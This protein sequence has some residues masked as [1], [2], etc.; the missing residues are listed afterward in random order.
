MNGKTRKPAGH[1][2]CAL[3]IISLLFQWGCA[4]PGA[5]RDEKSMETPVLET[6]ALTSEANRS[7]ITITS[8]TE[9]I[10]SPSFTLPSPPRICLDIKG[11]PS[12]TFSHALKAESGPVREV[13][14]Q[15]RGSEY[16]GIVIYLRE[17]GKECTI[18]TEGPVTRIVIGPGDAAKQAA[19]GE[20]APITVTP[21]L[22]RILNVQVSKPKKNT[23]RLTI[24]CEREL[25][26]Q[27]KPNGRNLALDLKD[28]TISP[29]LIKKLNTQSFEG[30]LESIKVVHP[31]GARDVFLNLT[32]RELSPYYINWEGSALHLDFSAFPKSA[33]GSSA[34]SLHKTSDSSSKKPSK[35]S[36][37]SSGKKDAGKKR[38]DAKA[39]MY[40][41][42]SQQYA[43]QRMSFDFVDTDIRNILRLISEVA[44][45]NIVWGTDVAGKI[46]MTMN[47]VPWDQAIEMILRPNGLTYQ[48]END[49]LWVVPK[50]KLV[51]MEIADK[52]RK[53]ALMAAKRLQGIFEAKIIEFIV[54]RNRKAADIY[55]ML[56]GDRTAKPPVMGILDIEGGESE[57]KEKG[58]EEQ[59]KST[60]IKAL[61]LYL[62]Y[63]AGTNMIVANG[64][65]AKIEKVKEFI[66]KLDVAERQVMIE[67]RVVEARTTFSRDLGIRWS[68]LDQSNPGFQADWL[69]TGSNSTGSTQ[70]S[71]NSP[72]TWSPNIGIAIG[73]LTGGG[74]GSIALDA[75][76]A[77]A[78]GN[79]EA[80]II[81]APR[82][83][84]VNGGE[85]EIKRGSTQYV[86]IKT[87]DTLDVQSME[88]NLSLKITPTISADNSHVT[89]GVLVT[90][91]VAIPPGS[92]NDYGGKRT[93]GVETTLMVKNG[94][95]VVIGGIY[96]KDDERQESG[97]PWAM[98]VPFLGW[99]FKAE[100]KTQE[101][102]ELLIFLTP[103]VINP[104]GAGT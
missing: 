23:T 46:S 86:P 26:Y 28:S 21:G 29:L 7:I 97:V 74:L 47:D 33:A 18:T 52:N 87:Q 85:A 3:I 98:D 77:L 58:E 61:D 93:K 13:T 22:P 34:P 101:R 37:R 50:S 11:I 84:T 69:N 66:S 104:M 19:G 48:I 16:T 60:K 17:E 71:T 5:T 53:N 39:V 73:W 4:T 75:S 24:N 89:L 55:K 65:R 12:S 15:D 40:E 81:S 9:T 42:T 95:T 27:L 70:F 102:Y 41:A 25:Q 57:E 90:D 63:D 31:E 100:Q 67:A 30:A 44:G 64:V 80:R 72:E 62:S 56:V 38:T 49:V 32:L 54:I 92:G 99:L 35:V 51:D 96:T 91:D 103:T 82:V 79:G 43:G 1:L 59:G 6:I 76:L 68:S 2:F 94:E 14:I 83:L 20:V 78:E 8:S 36:S 45:I 88:A 10:F